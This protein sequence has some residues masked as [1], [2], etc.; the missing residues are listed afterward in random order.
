MHENSSA[1]ISDTILDS[2]NEGVF[3]IDLNKRIIAFNASAERITKV[4]RS[5]AIGMCLPGCL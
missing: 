2:L 5:E 4:S 1:G 3:A